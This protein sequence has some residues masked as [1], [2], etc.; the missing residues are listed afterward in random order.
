LN[1]DQVP[2]FR[3]PT[4]PGRLKRGLILNE[5]NASTGALYGMNLKLDGRFWK[6]AFGETEDPG[7]QR[8]PVVQHFGQ[9]PEEPARHFS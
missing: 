7:H 1:Q 4:A 8:S 9:A 5:Q 6:R 3:I 2:R